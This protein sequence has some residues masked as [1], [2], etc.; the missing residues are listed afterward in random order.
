MFVSSLRFFIHIVTTTVQPHKF[1]RL[2][3]LVLIMYSNMAAYV[4]S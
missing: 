2:N 1:S 3:Y 4:V